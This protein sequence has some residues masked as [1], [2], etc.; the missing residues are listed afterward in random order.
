MQSV[1]SCPLHRCVPWK[2]TRGVL[3][4]ALQLYGGKDKIWEVPQEMCSG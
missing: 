2:P 3:S 4:P 1:V